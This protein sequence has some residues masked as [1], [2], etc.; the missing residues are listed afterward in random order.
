MKY[1][2][3]ANYGY[4]IKITDKEKNFEI[5]LNLENEYDYKKMNINQKIDMFDYLHSENYLKIDAIT[6]VFY[7]PKNKIFIE[8]INDNRFRLEMNID[9]EDIMFSY[10]KTTIDIP[11]DTL[12]IDA[13]FEFDYNYKPENNTKFKDMVIDDHKFTLTDILKK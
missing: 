4:F 12:N 2:I 10:N 1:N 13:E 6:Y 7:T 9:K 5:I 8:K 3:E 11:F